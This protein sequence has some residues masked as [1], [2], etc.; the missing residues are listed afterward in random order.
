MAQHTKGIAKQMRLAFYFSCFAVRRWSDCIRLKW[1]QIIK[2]RIVGKEVT[3]MKC[4]VDDHGNIGMY[5]MGNFGVGAGLGVAAGLSFG[6]NWEADKLDDVAGWGYS[7]GGFAGA[8]IFTPFEL[9][10]EKNGGFR[11]SKGTNN[12]FDHIFSPD[13]EILDGASV[14]LPIPGTDAASC[15]RNRTQ[16]FR[17]NGVGYVFQS[18]R[19]AK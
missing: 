7:I 19:Q 13:T 14:G 18:Y 6:W 11:N 4:M 8:A 10:F 5:V 2:Q 1:S 12:L 17:H 15:T 3:A 16:R 9:G